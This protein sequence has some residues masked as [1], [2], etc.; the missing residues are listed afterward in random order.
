L[1]LPQGEFINAFVACRPPG[2][3]ARY[4]PKPG[5]SVGFGFCFLNHA[6]GAA[7]HAVEHWGL[8]RVTVVDFD[9][10]HGG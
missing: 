1:L 10:H 8:K 4:D 2:H 3:H 5:E 9:L 6:A 7:L